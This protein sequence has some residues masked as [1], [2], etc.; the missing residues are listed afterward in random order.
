MSPPAGRQQHVGRLDQDHQPEVVLVGCVAPLVP[1][2]E[3]ELAQQFERGRGPAGRL[4]DALVE[5]L[6][7]LLLLLPRVRVGQGLERE[8][9]GPRARS[10]TGSTRPAADDGRPGPRSG[11]AR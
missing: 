11:S 1:G 4:A 10:S 9:V 2:A 8:V 3:R 5:G 7:E 6:F